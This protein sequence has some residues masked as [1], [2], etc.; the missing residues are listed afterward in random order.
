MILYLLPIMVS[1]V[2]VYLLIKLRFFYILHPIRTIKNTVRGVKSHNAMSALSLALAGT[3]GVGNIFGVAS[4][5]I[6]GGVGS[7]FWLFACSIFCSVIKYAEVTITHD[8]ITRTEHIHGGMAYCIKRTLGKYG[9]KVSKIYAF[10][11]LALA[12]IMGAGL[13]CGTLVEGVSSV[14]PV[15]PALISF[16]FALF[17]VFA[18][19]GGARKIEKMTA[20]LIPLST[21][22]YIIMTLSMI[23]MN[24]SNLPSVINA[25]VCDAFKPWSVIGGGVSA[26]FLPIKEGYCRGV[27]SNEA[28]CGTSGMAHAK[29]GI[30]NP[31]LAG[32][33]GIAEVNFDTTLM[34]TLTSLSVLVSVPDPNSYISPMALVISAFSY[35]FGY[36]SVYILIGLI[37]VF[38]YST[39]I[40]WY[41]YAEESLIFLGFAD[42]KWRIFPVYIVAVALLPLLG[43]SYLLFFT[44]ILLLF[45]SILTMLVLIKSSDRIKYLS[46]CGG[47]ITKKCMPL[48][49]CKIESK[50]SDS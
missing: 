16:T 15:K 14:T 10:L 26:A 39:V 19:I 47:V 46:E 37:F 45:M 30:L 17:V 48:F 9:G 20:F 24:F 3:L 33:M 43:N 8:N 50:K 11:T 49:N 6:I 23:F 41:Y 5:I 42:Y 18:I 29:S 2:G 22:I 28:G 13:Q 4:G 21:I 1:A 44:D 12:L 35:N 38:A 34:C 36:F 32:L 40:C 27:L 25:I 31:A 7:V